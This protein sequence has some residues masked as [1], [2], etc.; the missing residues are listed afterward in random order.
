VFVVKEDNSPKSR[1]L[2][3]IWVV[4]SRGTCGPQINS[5]PKV[6]FFGE[7]EIQSQEHASL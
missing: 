5:Y 2:K 7:I 1:S 6:R 4:G 3:L